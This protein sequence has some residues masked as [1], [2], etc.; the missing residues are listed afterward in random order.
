MILEKKVFYN[1]GTK[2]YLHYWKLLWNWWRFKPMNYAI[3][4]TEECGVWHPQERCFNGHF[5]PTEADKIIELVNCVK[6][7]LR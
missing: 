3:L 2:Q 4:M 7:W 1:A 6:V 5:K